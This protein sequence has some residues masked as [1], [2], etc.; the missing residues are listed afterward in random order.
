MPTWWSSAAGWPGPAL[1]S[2]P[3]A[4]GS[5][6]VAHPGPP[7][8]RR[9]RLQRSAPVDPRRHLAHGQQQPLGA[10][11]RRDRRNPRRE[12]VPQPRGQCAHPRYHPAGKS[13][14]RSRTSRC[15]S[16]PRCTS[17]KRADAD[18]IAAVRAFCSQNSTAYDV[19]APLFCDASGDGIV[20]FLAGAAFRMGA[21]ARDEF[22]EG[23]A[24]AS[25]TTANCSATRIYF[26]SKDTGRP[27]K[28]IAA[29][30]RAEGHHARSRAIATSRPPIP[31]A[32]SGGSS[33]AAAST[34][35]TRPRRS[36]GSC[37]R[38]STASGTTSRT[39]ASFPR[40]KP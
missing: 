29:Q 39:P 15:C 23:F 6:V 16:T 14:R 11:R 4:P 21:E 33:T 20:G 31:A 1:P 18:T 24:P 8:A 26:Y 17:S 3:R 25:R 34:R 30:L 12:P 35:S 5:R 22:G 7:R 40:P 10:R 28:F 32:A 27:V 2:P 19:S 38:S 9:Q 13:D 36:S 37:G